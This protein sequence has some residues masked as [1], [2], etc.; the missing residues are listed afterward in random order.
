[1]PPL[2]ILIIDDSEDDALI[3][4]REFRRGGFEVN[5]MRV[6]T[7][8]EMKAALDTQ[9]WDVVICDY[10]MPDFRI[11][12]ALT[13]LKKRGLDVPFIIVSGAIADETAAEAMKAG[14]H[15]YIRKDNLSRLLPSVERELR[16]AQIRKER[17]EAVA[18]LSWKAEMN[19]A[20][21]ELSQALIKIDIPITEI[22]NQTMD[23][24]RRLTDSSIACV[25]IIDSSA[26]RL[27]T[28][29]MTNETCEIADKDTVFDKSDGLW[30]WVLKEQK[31]LLTNSPSTDPRSGSTP[32]D[33]FP[34][35]RFLSVPAMIG[36][37]LVGQLAVANSNRDYSDRDLLSMERLAALL[38][39]AI[40]RKLAEDELSRVRA[41]VDDAT[42]AVLILDRSGKAVYLNVAF[43]HLFGHT[44]TGINDAG[45][46]SAFAD[47][48]NAK[49]IMDHVTQA[50][51]WQGEIDMVSRSSH[52]FPA[53]LRCSPIL[54]SQFDVIGALFVAS[55]ITDRRHIEEERLNRE[56]LQGV[57]E[58]AGAACHELNQPIQAISGHA[59]LL[60]MR[61]P[62]DDPLVKHARTI[63]LQADRM[64]GIT[65]KLRG[66]TRYETREYIGDIRIIDIDK[67]S[68]TVEKKPSNLGEANQPIT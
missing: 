15:D 16:E 36:D 61:L 30:G 18:T 20:L 46:E 37:K 62:D 17:N 21:A 50:V 47:K 19:A 66:I 42:E 40:Q 1:M 4:S 31:P 38:A 2:N 44:L 65:E 27:R 11:G 68:D 63:K 58:T 64:A 39:L 26:D 34:I 7:A 43:G 48:D 67:A 57:L 12:A 32:T 41:A 8:T 28:S 59:E 25:G 3:L 24:A 52:E 29:L 23:Y 56:K 10:S 35:E 5:R 55:D 13:M 33:H 53:L 49:T 14:A 22:S 6:E 60:M 9:S 45:F 51:S 54:D